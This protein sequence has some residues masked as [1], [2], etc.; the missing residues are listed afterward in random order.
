MMAVFE[1]NSST[2]KVKKK[3]NN[4]LPVSIWELWEHQENDEVTASEETKEGSFQ[5]P[6]YSYIVE[7]TA[8]GYCGCQK[9][10]LLQ[11]PLERVMEKNA[12]RAIKHFWLRKKPF[13]QGLLG[14]GK[15]NTEMLPSSA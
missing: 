9:F 8:Q 7:P 14:A 5:H 2:E 1:I 6:V 11:K 10:R 15:F 4:S 12:E 3:V 13:S